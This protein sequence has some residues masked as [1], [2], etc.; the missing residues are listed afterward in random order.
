MNKSQAH[1]AARATLP[2]VPEEVFSLWLDE[3]IDVLGWDPLH[4][5]WQGLFRNRPIAYWRNLPWHKLD[6]P[7]QINQLNPECQGIL[8]QLL[9]GLAGLPSQVTAVTGNSPARVGSILRYMQT[10]GTWPN[11]IIL[12]TEGTFYLVADGFH[13]LAAFVRIQSAPMSGALLRPVHSAWIG[14]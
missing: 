9:A 2:N 6:I 8:S 7:L 3:R 5:R 13:R 12:V 4:P 14:K 11:S 1:N 10:H